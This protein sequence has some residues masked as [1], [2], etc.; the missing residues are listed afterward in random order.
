MVVDV[1]TF[2]GEYDLFD[3]RYNIL[4]DYVDQFIV[5]EAPTT[6][7]GNQKP[8][9]F[10]KIKDKYEKVKY[11]IIDENYTKE[12]L[13]LARESPNTKGALHWQHEFLQKE[14]ILKSLT[15]LKDKDYVYI[16][17][18]DEIWNPEFDPV[19]IVDT[20]H[21]MPMGWAITRFEQIVYPYY[22][23]NRSTEYWQGTMLTRYRYIKNSILNHVRSANAVQL[24]MN[25]VRDGGWHFTSQGGEAEIRR[26]INDSYTTDSYNTGWVQENL[27]QNIAQRK[28]YIGR[29]FEMKIDENHWPGYLI[30]NREKYKH[31]CA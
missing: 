3:L 29:E 17:D 27:S 28:D 10:E 26:K 18:C 4:K 22:L 7:T 5:C 25:L 2:N 14:S 8:L 30:K 19:T 24:K 12:E 1:I 13:K 21:P 6:F 23:N 16:S 11:F 9:Y 31:L 20:N 15:H